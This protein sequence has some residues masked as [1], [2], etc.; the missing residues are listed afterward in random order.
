M[1]KGEAMVVI[2]R[3]INDYFENCINDS[4]DREKEIEFVL[5]A[6]DIIYE[7]SGFE[8]VTDSKGNVYHR[9]AVYVK[10]EEDD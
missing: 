9:E 10:G 8:K 6:M 5:R 3:I 2:M 1:N 4:E 7:A